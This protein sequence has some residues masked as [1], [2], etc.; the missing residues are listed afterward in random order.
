[1]IKTGFDE[2][3]LDLLDGDGD[4]AI[5]MSI[6]LDEKNK[7]NGGNRPS[8]KSGCCVLLLGLGSI[9]TYVWYFISSLI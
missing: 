6:L 7:G 9:G 3:P 1:M 5:E 4:D 8:G 2:N